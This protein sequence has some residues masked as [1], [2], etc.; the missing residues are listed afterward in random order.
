MDRIKNEN[1]VIPQGANLWCEVIIKEKPKTLII[2]PNK[3]LDIDYII[4]KK[5]GAHVTDVKEGDIILELIDKYQINHSYKLN[6][7]TYIQ[8]P[9]NVCFMITSADNMNLQ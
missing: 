7:K 4:V 6:N 2:D 9:R 5:V 1:E 8:I 3:P